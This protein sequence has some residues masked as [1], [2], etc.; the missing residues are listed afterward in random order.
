MTV[1]MD[2]DLDNLEERFASLQESEGY[3]EGLRAGERA[4]LEEG[5]EFGAVEGAKKGAEIGYLKGFTLTH[6]LTKSFSSKLTPKSEK[7][8][9]EILSLIDEFPKTNETDCED[10]LAKIRVKFKQ[11]FVNVSHPTVSWT[12]AANQ[13]GQSQ[14]DEMK[15]Q[16]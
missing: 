8:Y 14:Q 3:R 5:E 16:K 6:K 10:K 9:D 12:T 4:G 11:A 7:L 13:Q 2:L 1:D 15:S